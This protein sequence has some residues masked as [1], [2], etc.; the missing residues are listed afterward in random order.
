MQEDRKNDQKNVAKQQP[1]GPK[2][3]CFLQAH[4][5]RDSE[6]ITVF[7]ATS[8]Y[9]Y[10]YVV[11]TIKLQMQN[12]SVHGCTQ[13]HTNFLTSAC[14]DPPQSPITNSSNSRNKK[15]T[16]PNGVLS[17]HSVRP[18]TAVLLLPPP[19]PSPQFLYNFLFL[20]EWR[21]QQTRNGWKLARTKRNSNEITNSRHASAQTL[22]KM[23]KWA[24]KSVACGGTIFISWWLLCVIIWFR[25][26]PLHMVLLGGFTNFISMLLSGLTWMAYL[27]NQ[28]T[29]FADR[30]SQLDGGIHN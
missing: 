21:K 6:N 7:Q 10:T 20:F 22:N 28:R 3:S 29:L 23:R 8:I 17:T 13:L 27:V 1:L 9:T 25:S 4:T 11:H 12:L 14:G 15:N 24:T 26:S 30:R 2:Q 16:I 19:P 5:G 18:K